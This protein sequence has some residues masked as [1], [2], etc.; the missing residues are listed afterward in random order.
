MGPNGLLLDEIKLDAVD[1]GETWHV[2]SRPTTDTT[3]LPEQG[4]RS[5]HTVA[6]CNGFAHNG[7]WRSAM[8]DSN[9]VDRVDLLPKLTCPTC[10]RTGHEEI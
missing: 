8:H 6:G 4:E 7:M 3:L 1:G 9:I 5:P 2:A 10:G